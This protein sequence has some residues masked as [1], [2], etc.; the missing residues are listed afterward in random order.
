MKIGVLALQGAVSE[1]LKMIEQCG[2]QAVP[3]KTTEQL[4]QVQKL[5]IPGGE[6][7][8]IGRLL[9]RYRL[10]EKIVQLYQSSNIPIFGTC[11]G[12]ILLAKNI[13]GV[14]QDTMG[15]IDVSVRRNAFGRQ[16]DSFETDLNIS[17][18][19]PRVFK[20]IFIRAPFITKVGKNVE[21]LCCYDGN[22]VLAQEG[23]IIVSSFHPELGN[24]IR[25]H[26]YFINLQKT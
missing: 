8:T 16:I 2:H 15:L 19:K 3:V 24:D 9:S 6:S 20:G 26:Q 12:M 25:I 13:E 21:T 1:H 23:N 22:I 4:N 7:T 11:A 18:L 10:K 5:I 14:E 17:V